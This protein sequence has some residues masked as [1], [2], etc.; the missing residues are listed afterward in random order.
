MNLHKAFNKIEKLTQ[1][2]RVPMTPTIARCLHLAPSKVENDCIMISEG[3]IAPDGVWVLIKYSYAGFYRGAGWIK[4][5]YIH[6]FTIT[7]DQNYETTTG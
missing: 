7:D 2:V 5:N 6:N 1:F 4:T 3:H